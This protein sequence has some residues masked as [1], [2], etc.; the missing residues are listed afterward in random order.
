LGPQLGGVAVA[1]V[2]E[3]R[4]VTRTGF[5]PADMAGTPVTSHTV[6]DLASLGKQFTG[7]A[8]LILADR[9][10]IAMDDDARK[11]L[12]ELPVFDRSRPIRLED[13]SH[14]T[15][16]LPE[17]PRNE[18]TPTQTDVLAW[19]ST[20]TKLNFQTGT[21]WEYCNLNY[22]LLARVVERVTG[23]TLRVFLEEEVFSRAGMKDAQILDDPRGSI[24]GRATGYCFGKPCRSVDA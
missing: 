23:K 3:G 2:K 16:G 5:G 21:R 19:L 9:K 8:L 24:R 12:P 20:Q 13:L 14:H 11:Y 6:F 7:I 17:F 22:F 15:S 18:K 4:V 10:E 1:V